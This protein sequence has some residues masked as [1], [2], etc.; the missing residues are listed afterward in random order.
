[1]SSALYSMAWKYGSNNAMDTWGIQYIDYHIVL[2]SE[3]QSD[4]YQFYND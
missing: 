4:Q 2:T 1:M 3:V